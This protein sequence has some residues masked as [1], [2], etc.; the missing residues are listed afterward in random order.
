MV[1]IARK[2]HSTGPNFQYVWLAVGEPTWSFRHVPSFT[3][4]LPYI[5]DLEMKEAYVLEDV[6]PVTPG[7]ATMFL[8]Q[9]K[10]REIDIPRIRQAHP[11]ATV[12]DI[13]DINGETVAIAVIV[14]TTTT[15]DKTTLLKTQRIS[16]LPKRS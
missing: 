15:L 16:D 8:V 1:A 12:E 13:K 5:Q 2:L 9:L 14:A 7:R 10:R 11:N 3:V 4:M 6:V